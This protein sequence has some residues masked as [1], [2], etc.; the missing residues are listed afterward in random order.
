MRAIIIGISLLLFGFSSAQE[1]KES[2]AF[3]ADFF[4]GN[5]FK[6]SP[7]LSHLVTGHPEGILLSFSKKHMGIKNGNRPITSR[8]TVF[9]S[10]IKI[11]KMNF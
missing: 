10:Y 11:S 1:I 5:I 4:T 7:D 8:I 3:E 2:N 9:I 6:H